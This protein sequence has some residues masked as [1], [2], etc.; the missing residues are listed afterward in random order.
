[1]WIEG[2]RNLQNGTDM[3]AQRQLMVGQWFYELLFYI[4]SEVT[5]VPCEQTFDITGL[6]QIL[7][8]VAQNSTVHLSQLCASEELN[9]IAD[10][11]CDTDL[12]PFRMVWNHYVFIF[13]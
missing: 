8:P 3:S 6:S 13:T 12:Y 4:K 1:M 7:V 9:Q 2:S 5:N 10:L 11:S